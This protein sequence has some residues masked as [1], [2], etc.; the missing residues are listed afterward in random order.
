[1]LWNA[2][3]LA[4]Y[5]DGPAILKVGQDITFLKQAQERAMQAERLAA[6]G[7]MMTGLAHESRNALGRSQACLEMLSLVVRDRPEAID[8]INRIQKAQD[9]LHALYEDVRGYAAP[10]KLEKVPCDL[11]AIWREAWAHLES[12]RD[13]KRGILREAVDSADV[14]CMADAFRLEQVLHN[15]LD[16]ALA[17][18]SPPVEVEIRAAATEL[19][20]Q[21][22]L[23]IAV[24]DNGPGIAPEQRYQVFDPFFTTKAKGTGLGM[25]IAKRIVEAHGGRISVGDSEGPGA[26]FLITLPRGRP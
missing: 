14:S 13:A 20:G 16:N 18:G 11:R 9:H 5:E 1:M 10:I 19:D 6:I 26:V 17:A 23:R 22:A 12:A 25:A 2:R 8:L 15:I 21:P 4:D 24:A 7:Q 3:Y